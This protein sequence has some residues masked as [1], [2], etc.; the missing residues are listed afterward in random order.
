MPD[1]SPMQRRVTAR[2]TPDYYPQ[3]QCLCGACH[4]SCCRDGWSIFLSKKEYMTLRRRPDVDGL[5]GRLAEAM[6]RVRDEGADDQCYAR[7]HQPDRH[8]PL[9]NQQG[10][11]SLQLA[12]GA[13][14]LPQ[15]CRNFPRHSAATPAGLRQELCSVGCEAVL[16][17]LFQQRE[18]LGFIH[19]PLPPQEQGH[20]HFDHSGPVSQHFAQLQE[21]GID[22]LQDRSM[23]LPLRMLTLG[24]FLRDVETRSSAQEPWDLS[25]WIAQRRALI[26]TPQLRDQLG[27]L[28]GDR[29]LALFHNL[30]LL[31]LFADHNPMMDALRDDVQRVLDLA[32][33]PDVVGLRADPARYAQAERELVQHYGDLEYFYENILVNTF[34]L[35][36]IPTES[37][38]GVTWSRYLTLCDL[39]GICRFMAVCCCQG[40]SDLDR[41]IHVLTITCRCF[42]HDENRRT[43]MT[44]ELA[45]H[46]SDTLTDMAVVLRG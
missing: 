41:L 13:D 22:I 23:D 30:K 5:A 36:R 11:C 6:V 35:L 9:L 38:G 4:N 45:H 2:L 43:W 7:F 20:Y 12:H 28:S 27:R 32:L 39:Y 26:Q 33:L 17:L 37:E 46:G 18:G 25:V 16:H 8:C 14:A 24:W 10:L 40:H 15:I 31:M 3:F 44:R 34:F 42:L 21:L 1:A 29:D 19:E